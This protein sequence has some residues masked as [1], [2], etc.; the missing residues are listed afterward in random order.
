G[1][2]NQEGAHNP[3]RT[4]LAEGK[5]RF[6]GEPIAVVVAQSPE[7]ARDAAN[8][9]MVDYDALPAA[10]DMEA[11]LEPGAPLV[12]DELGTNDCFVQIV[13]NGDVDAAFAQADRVVERRIV[14]QRV[15]ALPMECRAALAEYR[16][17]AGSLVIYL[18]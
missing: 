11:A 8:V 14:N 18:G 4:L 9:V 3:K 10:I 1:A 6:V 5:V 12:H 15:A 7:A 2:S 13:Q 17:G 16:R